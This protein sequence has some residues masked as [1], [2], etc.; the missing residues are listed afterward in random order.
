MF[1]I[2]ILKASLDV[3]MVISYARME[4]AK[5]RKQENKQVEV[6]IEAVRAPIIP[7]FQNKEKSLSYFNL[8]NY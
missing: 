5:K 4:D 3:E 1:Y 2:L 7:L 6:L 8:Y